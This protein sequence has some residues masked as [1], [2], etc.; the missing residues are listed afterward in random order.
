[1]MERLPDAYFDRMYEQSADPWQL[2]ER[3]YEQRKFAITMALLL[4]FTYGLDPTVAV[5]V[6]ASTYVGAEYGGFRLRSTAGI[7]VWSRR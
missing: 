3:W 6:L 5:V 7:S 1:M 4:P 2:Q